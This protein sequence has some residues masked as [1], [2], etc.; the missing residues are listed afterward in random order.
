MNTQLTASISVKR[1]GACWARFC[2]LFQR[3][4]SL[5]WI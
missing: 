3:P 4:L 2:L 1:P 5:F